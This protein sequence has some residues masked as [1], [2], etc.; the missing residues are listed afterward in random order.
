MLHDA[1]D[2]VEK[3]APIA[4][5]HA[6][7]PSGR[8]GCACRCSRRLPPIRLSHHSTGAVEHSQLR[9][10]MLKLRMP[11]SP[12]LLAALRSAASG[13]R[14]TRRTHGALSEP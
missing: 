10:T 7:A 14:R 6:S 9:C 8:A 12:L 11:P 2:S 3:L 5:Q 13:Q 1:K 4:Q